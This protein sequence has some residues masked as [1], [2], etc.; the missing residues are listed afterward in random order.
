MLQEA[1]YLLSLLSLPIK[2]VTDP[3]EESLARAV[4]DMTRR[5]EMMER[6]MEPPDRGAC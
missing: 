1:E 2:L 6:E 4:W 3:P 5:Q